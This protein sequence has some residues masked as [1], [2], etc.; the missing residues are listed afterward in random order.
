MSQ[1]CPGV[2]KTALVVVAVQGAPCAHANHMTGYI[3]N[4]IST[5]ISIS[6]AKVPFSLVLGVFSQTPNRTVVMVQVFPRT[7][8]LNH[9]SVLYGS[10]Q[11]QKGFEPRTEPLRRIC[12]DTAYIINKI[13]QYHT[14]W[15]HKR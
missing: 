5:R 12:R 2:G 7:P 4:L 3:M 13:A 8:N 9:G 11:V 1:P 10:V 15:Y 6:V 14:V